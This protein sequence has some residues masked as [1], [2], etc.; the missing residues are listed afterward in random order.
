MMSAL[1]QFALAAARAEFARGLA[2]ARGTKLLPG[3][4]LARW[5]CFLPPWAAFC[6]VLKQGWT[7]SK[8][9]SR[10]QFTESLGLNS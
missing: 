3:L 10:H 7:C 6:P 8:V 2:W 9:D 4:A 1:H 5:S